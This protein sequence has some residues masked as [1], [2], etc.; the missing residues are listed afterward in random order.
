MLC[1]GSIFYMV[2]IL[3]HLLR[4]ILLP[5]IWPILVNVHTHLRRI[6]SSSLEVLLGG[7]S[8]EYRQ[9]LSSWQRCSCLLYLYWF[10]QST[11]LA[12]AEGVDNFNYRWESVYLSLLSNQF[13][14]H[15]FWNLLFRNKQAYL[16]LLCPLWELLHYFLWYSFFMKSVWY[17]GSYSGFLLASD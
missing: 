10:F 14:L 1:P 13:L 16:W 15:I 3:S 6:C 11:V 2:Y 5:G 12:I 7:L 8:Y 17:Q 9:G 4:C